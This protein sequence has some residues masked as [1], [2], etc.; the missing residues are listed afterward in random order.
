MRKGIRW[1]SE[2]RKEIRKEI[3][4]VNKKFARARKKGISGVPS[5][6][7][8]S[9]I[10]EQFASRYATR[11][12][13]RRQIAA[14]RRADIQDLTKIAQ[15]ES[16]EKISLYRLKEARR[17]STRLLRKMRRDIRSREI[18]NMGDE[19]PFGDTELDRMYN[20]ESMLKGGIKSLSDYAKINEAYSNEYSSLKKDSFEE[21]FYDTLD[22]Q[23]D[24]SSLTDNQKLELKSKL[25]SMD[26]NTLIDANRNDD[27]LAEV[28]DRYK[29]EYNEQDKS[30]VG[31]AI[32]KLYNNI[33][34]I[35]EEYSV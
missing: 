9:A 4:K 8:I 18:R 29:S 28:L 31:D 21:A 2:F 13:V 34:R 15:L 12:E 7:R 33:D 6:L 5:N 1:D 25:R 22:K 35:V 26:I 24:Y 17:K 16:G 32:T 11:K 3:D 23:I 20:V 27:D 10:R 19:L 30:L 14:Y